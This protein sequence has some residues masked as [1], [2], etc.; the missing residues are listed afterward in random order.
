MDRGFFSLTRPDLDK[1]NDLDRIARVIAG[2]ISSSSSSSAPPSLSVNTGV[3]VV[4]ADPPTSDDDCRI[5]SYFGELVPSI[6]FSISALTV[7]NICGE[8]SEPATSAAGKSDFFGLP[9]DDSFAGRSDVV[10]AS[11]VLLETVEAFEFDSVGL[12]GPD[13]FPNFKGCVRSR[14]RLLR[15]DALPPDE[16]VGVGD[17]FE[18]PFGDCRCGRDVFDED[19]SFC[20]ILELLVE[21]DWPDSLCGP[22]YPIFVVVDIFI[23]QTGVYYYVPRPNYDHYTDSSVEK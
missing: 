22:E 9:D 20:V 5:L 2:A 15:C 8:T 3:G 7:E 14:G 16:G 19:L 4:G 21:E 18:D 13:F 23:Y 11:L 10:M 1:L 6:L 12:G 17:A